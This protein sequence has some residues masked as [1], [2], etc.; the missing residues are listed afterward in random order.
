MGNLWRDLKYGVRMVASSPGFTVVAVVT[1]ALGIA[2][3]TTIF[4]VIDGVLLRPLRYDHPE[5]IVGFWGAGSWSPG[6]LAFMREQSDSYEHIAAYFG[7]DFAL[8]GRDEPLSVTGVVASSNLL[9]VL[10]VQ[11]ALGRGFLPEEDEPGNTQVVLLSDGLWRRVFG[12]DPAVVGRTV[13]LDD[14]SYEVIGVMP[15]GFRFPPRE[16]ALWVPLEMNPDAPDYRKSFYLGLVARLLPGVTLE[17]AQAELETVVPR[18]QKEFELPDGFDKLATPPAVMSY[19]EQIV[20]NVRPALLVLL[21][22]VGLVLL[23]ACANVANLLLARAIGRNR[24][25]A[26]RSALG[27]GRRAIVRQ[28]L[29]ESTLLAL[30]GGG[31][32]LLVSV[33]GV[34]VVVSGLPGDSPRVDEIGVDPRVLVFCLGLSLL[35]VLLFGLA[36]ALRA[37][38][39]NLSPSLTEGGRSG[40][41][42]ARRRTRE[43]LVVAEVALAVVLVVAAGLLSRSFL[44]LSRVDPGFSSS[45]VLSLRVNL[46]SNDYAD[47]GRRL[48]FYDEVLERLANL[49]GVEA[50]GANW[51]LP[52]A[53][54]GAFQTL[55]VEG[56][57]PAPDEPFRSVYWRTI[58]GDY[59]QAMGMPLLAGRAFSKVDRTDSPPVCVINQSMAN[60]YWPEGDAVGKRIQT[61]LDGKRWITV[62]GVTGD[63]KHNGLRE[64]VQPL[65]Y[66]PYSQ[67]PRWIRNLSLVVHSSLDPEALSGSA[68]GAVWAVDPNVP[69]FRVES[70]EQVLADSISSQRLTAAL[71]GLFGAL[72]LA[73]AAIGVFGVLSFTVSQRTNEIG[74]RMALGAGRSEVLRLV[75]REGM[76][77]ATVGVGLGVLG[78]LALTRLL[79]GLLFGVGPTDPLTFAAVL[80]LL[81]SVSFVACYLPGRRAAAVEPMVAL[82]YE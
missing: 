31:L 39:A 72:A 55:E 46:A 30:L 49:P 67:S 25:I 66:R 12:A 8:T 57:P 48:A 29:A 73:L 17:Q 44:A 16:A 50:A 38:R 32:G 24:E 40:M 5:R 61:G 10:G 35:T 60:R 19:Q 7:G 65:L 70:M 47:R 21:A 78:A 62:V 56:Q 4:T 42:G 76:M 15:P 51:R 22:A 74:I 34:D 23:I 11:P 53:D 9:S 68:R 20:G 77:L 81:T 58:A 6:E 69:V 13:R 79:S 52:V 45:E 37:S 64:E 75:L 18:L 2:A 80:A 33:W 1:L 41:Q 71:I 59:F 27:A 26:I 63:V 3:N 54:S 14:L 36:P 82:R 28:L 43:I